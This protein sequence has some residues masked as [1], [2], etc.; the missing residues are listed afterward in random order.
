MNFLLFKNG[1]GE[2]KNY[3]QGINLFKYLDKKKL[4]RKKIV[5]RGWATGALATVN[6]KKLSRKKIVTPISI[7]NFNNDN[8][9][10]YARKNS[11]TINDILFAKT[12]L[13]Q[14]KHFLDKPTI[15]LFL[16]LSE[17]DLSKGKRHRVQGRMQSVLMP[18]TNQQKVLLF[19]RLNNKNYKNE[20]A[21][22]FIEIG[23]AKNWNYHGKSRSDKN[24]FDQK[25]RN[26]QNYYSKIYD[27]GLQSCPL[28]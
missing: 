7:I 21:Y 17:G 3:R 19:C 13:K 25:A 2:L 20:S 10:G 28:I 8:Y 9:L 26:R 16:N 15:R 11:T 22:I 12:F 1:V 27:Q 18:G 23:D 4:S 24:M 5:T 14:L 6:K